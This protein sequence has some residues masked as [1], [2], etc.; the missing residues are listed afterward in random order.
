MLDQPEK[1]VWL[2]QKIDQQTEALI[3]LRNTMTR[4]KVAPRTPQVREMATAYQT[5]SENSRQLHA[6]LAQHKQWEQQL[7]ANVIEA[8]RCYQY[9]QTVTDRQRLLHARQRLGRCRQAISQIE[10]AIK[11]YES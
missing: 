11:R 5:L 4:K 8:E 3:R 9:S 2:L 6:K 10:D 1:L 7:L